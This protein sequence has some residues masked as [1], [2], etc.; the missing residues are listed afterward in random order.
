MKGGIKAK[1]SESKSSNHS[2][3]FLHAALRAHRCSHT[4][5]QICTSSERHSRWKK[6]QFGPLMAEGIP[7]LC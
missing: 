6:M 2:L 4:V 3:K 5:E 7:V 1:Q